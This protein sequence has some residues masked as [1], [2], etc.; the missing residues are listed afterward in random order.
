MEKI[1]IVKLKYNNT[2]V[3]GSSNMWYNLS[4]RHSGKGVVTVKMAAQ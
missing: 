3:E 1:I 2:K 4:D